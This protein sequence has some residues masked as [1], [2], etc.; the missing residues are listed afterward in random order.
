LVPWHPAQA[1]LS[2][3]HND[4][5][6]ND[7]IPRGPVAALQV[8]PVSCPHTPSVHK[9]AAVPVVGATLSDSENDAPEAVLPAVALQVLLPTVQLK[10][11]APQAAS[12]AAAQVAPEDCVQEPLLQTNEAAPLVPTVSESAAVPPE[13]VSAAVASQLL[14]P[15]IQDK[16]PALQD[17]GALQEVLVGVALHVPLALQSKAAVPVVDPVLSIKLILVL[18]LAAVVVASHALPPAVQLNE[19]PAG[20][21]LTTGALQVVLV[22]APN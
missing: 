6:F 9:A 1:G 15:T 13:A 18:G 11:C 8:P 3:V 22:K 12:G 10:A 21:S 16:A 20:Q 5:P 2:A 14:P 7:E 19:V 17:L 4:S